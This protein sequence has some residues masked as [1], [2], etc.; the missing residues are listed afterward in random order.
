MSVDKEISLEVDTGLLTVTDLN[1]IDAE[2]YEYV[3]CHRYL[4]L[5]LLKNI[6]LG[7]T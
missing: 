4:P 3:Q 5:A 2:S 6:I 7:P 1:P